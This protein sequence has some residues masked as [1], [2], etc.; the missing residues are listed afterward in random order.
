MTVEDERGPGL[1]LYVIGSFY[2]YVTVICEGM[3]TYFHLLFVYFIIKV[4]GT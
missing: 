3:P 2:L 1:G 4:P